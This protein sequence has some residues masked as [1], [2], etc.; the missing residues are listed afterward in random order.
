[1]VVFVE[2]TVLQDQS[3][4]KDQEFVPVIK[5]LCTFKEGIL[6]F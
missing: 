5:K 4:S 6:R 3:I 2:R 1:M